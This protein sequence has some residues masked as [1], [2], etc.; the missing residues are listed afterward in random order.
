MKG[1]PRTQIY[2]E[3]VWQPYWLDVEVAK[4]AYRRAVEAA[5]KRRVKAAGKIREA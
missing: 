2:Y 5:R 1:K 3:S 4:A